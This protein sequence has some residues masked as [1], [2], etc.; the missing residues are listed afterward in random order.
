MV[1]AIFNYSLVVKDIPQPYNMFYCT[2]IY[3]MSI[4]SVCVYEYNDIGSFCFTF[5]TVLLYIFEWKCKE[6]M[7]KM[8][9][10][11]WWVINLYKVRHVLIKKLFLY[12]IIKYNII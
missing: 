5:Y 8:F 3:V 7:W 2:C 4:G 9:L 11:W 10:E 1:I 6:V 12:D